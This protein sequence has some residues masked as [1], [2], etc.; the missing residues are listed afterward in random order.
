[1]AQMSF[2]IEHYVKMECLRVTED[3]Y[4]N[5][6]SIVEEFKNSLL[7]DQLKKLNDAISRM[8]ISDYCGELFQKYQNQYSGWVF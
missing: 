7:Q 8:L 2:D 1:M 4:E 3:H 6:Y 5:G